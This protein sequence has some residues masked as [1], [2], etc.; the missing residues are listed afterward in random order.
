MREMLLNVVNIFFFWSSHLSSGCI[1]LEDCWS[2]H[3]WNISFKCGFQQ[4][5]N[6][7]N[8]EDIAVSQMKVCTCIAVWFVYMMVI[9]P[10]GMKALKDWR[11]LWI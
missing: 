9:V 4:N 3:L 1:V 2:I 6:R 8:S 10:W 11:L 7:N 5:L